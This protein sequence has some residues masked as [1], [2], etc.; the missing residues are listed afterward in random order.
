MG[1]TRLTNTVTRILSE[2][3]ATKFAFKMDGIQVS[4]PGLGFVGSAIL[5]GRIQCLTAGEFQAQ[6]EHELAPGKMVSARYDIDKNA[7]VFE[8]DDYGSLPGEDRTIVHEAVHASFDLNACPDTKKH[9][10]I[11]DEAAAVLT[12]A[13][14]ILLCNR[15]IGGFLMEIEGPRPP[16]MELA[17]KA[18]AATAGFTKG[19][20][21]Y[22][23]S[24]EELKPLRAATAKN[25][26]LVRIVESKNSYTDNSGLRYVYDGIEKCST[27]KKRK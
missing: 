1:N 9:L 5:A 19:G 10:A 20:G 7:L 27:G 23:F 6:R 18:M 22:A 14:Y 26:N 16:A 2:V 13:F 4:G 21:P 17:K 25:W 24:A 3:G 8:S 15:P 11:D 12:E